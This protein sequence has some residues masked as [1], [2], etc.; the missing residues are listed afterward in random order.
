M[1][2]YY[3]CLHHILTVFT[4]HYTTPSNAAVMKVFS[5]L[6]DKFLNIIVRNY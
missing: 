2:S 4:L 6:Q 3:H 1:F 5:T